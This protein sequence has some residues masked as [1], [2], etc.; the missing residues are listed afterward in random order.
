MSQRSVQRSAKPALSREPALS[1]DSSAVRVHSPDSRHDPR[2]PRVARG[3]AVISAAAALRRR[4]RRP[5]RRTARASPRPHP[6]TTSSPPHPSRRPSPTRCPRPAPRHAPRR[7]LPREVPHHPL[8]LP[9]RRQPLDPQPTVLPAHPALPPLLSVTTPRVPASCPGASTPPLI[10]IPAQ[11]PSAP[12]PSRRLGRR[13]PGEVWGTGAGA[14]G[15]RGGGR[16]GRGGDVPGHG[17]HGPPIRVYRPGSPGI[18]RPPAPCTLADRPLPGRV[19]A[20][21]PGNQARN[22]TATAWPC[23]GPRASRWPQRV[24]RL[25]PLCSAS[26]APLLCCAAAAA[27]ASHFSSAGPEHAADSAAAYSGA[28]AAEARLPCV[29]GQLPACRSTSDRK[30]RTGRMRGH[31]GACLRSRASHGARGRASHGARGRACRGRSGA[32]RHAGGAPGG[33]GACG[34]SC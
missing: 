25:R 9:P 22:A 5:H 28:A 23:E 29:S 14:G 31:G 15:G 20:D 21:S 34:A 13:A 26:R 8:I 16:G 2:R 27:A 10:H 12:C 4:R 17:R 24:R 33:Q 1:P 18:S 19:W 6:C 7:G 11:P 30:S 32:G 3:P